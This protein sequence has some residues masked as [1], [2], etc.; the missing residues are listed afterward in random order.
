MYSRFLAYCIICCSVISC[1]DYPEYPP[2]PQIEYKS[3]HAY[4]TEDELGNSEKN[5]LLSF[6]LYDGDGNI[7]HGQEQSDER[8]FFCTFHVKHKGTFTDLSTLGPD[9]NN[10][11]LPQIRSEDNTKFIQA[12]VSVDMAHSESTLP[13]DTIFCTFYVQDRALNKSNT[14]TTDILIFR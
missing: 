11:I 1:V 7:G 6:M 10:Y 3:A 12:E 14:D 5:V 2:E 13:Y 9:S 8:D 4:F